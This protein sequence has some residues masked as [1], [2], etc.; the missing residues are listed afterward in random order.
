MWKGSNV[1][2]RWVYYCTH[3]KS[4]GF[5]QEFISS[6]G[7][8]ILNSVFTLRDNNDILTLEF[9]YYLYDKLQT[10]EQETGQNCANIHNIQIYAD[11]GNFLCVHSIL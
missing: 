9:I 1:F 10:T 11:I 8:F 7:L 5:L 4:I 2:Y 6:Y 3:S